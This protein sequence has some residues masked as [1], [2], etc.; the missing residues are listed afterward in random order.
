[1]T[2]P[3]GHPSLRAAVALALAELLGR[4]SHAEVGRWLGVVQTTITR[5]GEDLR[6]WPAD[7][8]LRLAAHDP[9][10]ALALARCATGVA[11]ERP[12]PVRAIG[13]LLAEVEAGGELTREIG[14]TLRDGRVHPG[15]ARRLRKLIESRQRAESA[16]LVDLKAIEGGAA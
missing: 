4:V 9:D 14:A 1:M 12:E 7:D 2:L 10:M 13:E 11:G 3:P 16:L 15:E 6:G 8:L 5:R